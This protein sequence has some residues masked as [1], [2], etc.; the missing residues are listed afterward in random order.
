M[1]PKQVHKLVLKKAQEYVADFNYE[2]IQTAI[3]EEICE[4]VAASNNLEKLSDEAIILAVITAFQAAY[5]L[6][7]KMII[8]L[9]KVEDAVFIHYRG[10]TFEFNKS[11]VL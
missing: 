10:K 7:K 4:N 1:T 5:D 8:A 11:S 3:F 6:M 9:V 2:G